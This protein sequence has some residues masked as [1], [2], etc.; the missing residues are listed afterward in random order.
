MVILSMVVINGC[1]GHTSFSDSY[2]DAKFLLHE[3]G[4]ADE[5]AMHTRLQSLAMPPCM[6][7]NVQNNIM[8]PLKVQN[9]KP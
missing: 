3:G 9:M 4:Q 2:E 1:L 6:R 5:Q 8:L 7:E